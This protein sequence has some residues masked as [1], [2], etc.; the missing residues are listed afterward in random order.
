MF[1]C[2]FG[3][4]K[5]SNEKRVFTSES[6][7]LSVCHRYQANLKSLSPLYLAGQWNNNLRHCRLYCIICDVYKIVPCASDRAQ[8]ARQR[9]KWDLVWMGTPSRPSHIG[10]D[11]DIPIC[12]RSLYNNLGPESVDGPP[13]WP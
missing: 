9:R 3:K 12:S 1:R 5:Y 6:I 10:C 13:H 8:R 11:H 7:C 4:T 2:S